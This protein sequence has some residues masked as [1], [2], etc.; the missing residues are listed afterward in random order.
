MV[1]PVA[2]LVGGVFLVVG[3]IQLARASSEFR[4]VYHIVTNDPVPIR[5][6]PTRSG[7]VEIEGTAAVAD[8]H[9]PVQSIFTE[10]PCLA[11]EYEVEEYRSSGKSSSWHTLDQGSSAVPFVV[12]DETGAVRVRPDDAEF[13]FEDHTLR[14]DGGEEPPE[15]IREYIDRTDD[16]DPQDKSLDVVVTELNYGN[17][18]RFTERR[19]DPGED[20]YVYGT[21]G[22]GPGGEWGSRLVDAVV[23]NGP[24]IPEFVVSDT[25][26]AETAR[27]IRNGA[28]WRGSIGLFFGG[29]GIVVLLLTVL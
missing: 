29:V 8:D 9:D 7:P 10:T 2:L 12:E 23:E 3:L 18:Q 20:V 22:R 27:R 19:L 17:D 5:E 24:G 15:R 26:E 11:Y 28:L 21:A 6:L 25:T 14:V 16:V 13:R 4:T 1:N